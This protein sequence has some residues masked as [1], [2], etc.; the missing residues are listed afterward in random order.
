MRQPRAGQPGRARALPTRE[1]SPARGIFRFMAKGE[2][3][4]LIDDA[5]R[6]T[7]PVD[8]LLRRLKVVATRARIAELEDN[9]ARR[10]CRHELNIS[11]HGGVRCC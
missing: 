9:K 7:V 2:L 4:R 6:S 1:L 10:T 3:E 5:A 8:E 11:V